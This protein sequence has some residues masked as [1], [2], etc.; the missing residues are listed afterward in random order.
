MVFKKYF[1]QW[2]QLFRY[3]STMMK[4]SFVKDTLAKVIFLR[5]Y[6]KGW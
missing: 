2:H 3:Y 5:K 6:L 1:G 4:E